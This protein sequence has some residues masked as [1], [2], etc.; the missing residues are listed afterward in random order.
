MSKI[1]QTAGRQQ[2]GD[3][4]PNFA[5]F[6]DDILFGEQ[7]NDD[8]IDTKQKCIVTVVALVSSGVT[9]SSLQ[10][11]LQNA[12]NNGVTR[13]EIACIISHVGFYAG[14]PKAWAAFRLA[15]EVWAQPADNAMQQ[16][17]NSILLPIGQPNTAFEQYFVGQSYLYPLSVAA[18]VY[19]VTFSPAC[20]N[21]WHIHHATKGG[22]QLLVCIGG[23]GWYQQWGSKPI[24]MTAGT[25]VEIPANVKH[26]HGAAKDS[27][28]AHIAVEIPGENTS[29]EWC[30]AVDLQQYD[31]LEEA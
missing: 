18:G 8:A 9:D 21:N 14:W 29:N 22:G 24:K 2:L 11:H 12:K 7:W 23:K 26:W 28:F 31:N 19:N 30:E 13:E 5:H 3:F 27:W 4:A 25:I 20:R 16:F 1:K 6:N 10:F 15:K 17:Q